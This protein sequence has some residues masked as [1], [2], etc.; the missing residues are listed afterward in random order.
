MRSQGAYFEGDRG[1][2]VLCTMFL[3]SSINMSIFHSM[4]LDT[5][6][7]DLTFSLGISWEKNYLV[8]KAIVI[9][10]SL[11]CSAP[12]KAGWRG[13]KSITH[14]IPILVMAL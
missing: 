8:T 10:K 13:Y 14:K 5:F 2:I 11:W 9:Q 7:T 4:W 1:V 3:V 6:W 12:D